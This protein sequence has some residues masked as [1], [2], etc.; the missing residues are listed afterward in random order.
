MD[1]PEIKRLAE[2]FH[3]KYEADEQG[4]Y[5]LRCTTLILPN[6]KNPPNAKKKLPPLQTW[7]FD[8]VPELIEVPRI[9]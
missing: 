1:D 5:D 7:V 4:H 3:A 6:P 2:V 9:K 8:P